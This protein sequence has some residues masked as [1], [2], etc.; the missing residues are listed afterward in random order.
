MG[1]SVEWVAWADQRLTGMVISRDSDH[2]DG[3]RHRRSN[4]QAHLE[5][6]SSVSPGGGPDSI[7]LQAK[8]DAE[9]Q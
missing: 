6:P 3:L 8:S 2:A 1:Q 9:I 5:T 4:E 7:P